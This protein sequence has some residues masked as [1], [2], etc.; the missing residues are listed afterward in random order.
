MPLCVDIDVFPQHLKQYWGKFTDKASSLLDTA[1]NSG[2][3]YTDVIFDSDSP[4]MHFAEP[5]FT[6]LGKEVRVGVVGLRE[7]Y[8]RLA[9]GHGTSEK[10]FAVVLGYIVLGLTLALYLNVLTVG[11]VRNAGRAVRSA[12]R[13]QLL[14]VKVRGSV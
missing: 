2:R 8:V 6:A 10:I 13:Q 3:T 12:V 11:N 14:V 4:V 5:Y 1:P 7:T 9:L